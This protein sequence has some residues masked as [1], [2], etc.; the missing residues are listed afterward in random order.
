MNEPA[1]PLVGTRVLDLSRIVSGPLCGRMLADLGADVVKIEPPGGDPTRRVPPLVDGISAYYAQV[2]A[3]KRNVC[4]DLKAPDGPPLVARLAAEV[5]VLIENFRP[6]V[7][8]RYGLDAPTLLDANS[9]LVYCSVTGWG[10]DGPWKDRRAYAPL[11]HA[12]VGTLELAARHRHRRPEYDVNQHADVY[13]ALLATSAVLASLLERVRTGCGQH[14]DLAMGQAATYVNEWAAV[15]LGDPVDEYAGFDTWNH[16]TYPLGDGSYVAL[17]GNPVNQFPGWAAKL[18][19]SDDLLADPRFSTREARAE[20]LGDLV[21]AIDELTGRFPDFEAVAAVL[22]PWMLAAQVR[23]VSTL[24]R[25]E[26]ALQRGLVAEVAPGVPV[27]AA[28][29]RTSGSRVGVRPILAG[30]GADNVAVFGELGY[31]A[32]EIDALHAAGVLCTEAGRADRATEAEA[33]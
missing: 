11:V 14:L 9:R 29:W 31:G 7:L 25:T 19:A 17:I 2:N 4:I 18:G 24:A 28:P 6:G 3:G 21:A 26:W 20:H 15:N 12:E 10:Q 13:T 5:D 33:G 1:G 27:P 22:D 8:A 23:S 30:L 32:D 16:F